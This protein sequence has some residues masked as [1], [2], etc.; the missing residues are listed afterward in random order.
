MV[1]IVVTG[2]RAATTITAEVLPEFELDR[3]S[4]DVPYLGAAPE[5]VESG[6]VV[7]VEQAIQ[8]IDGIK[9]IVSTASEGNAS[10]VVE[11]ALGADPKR[12]LDELTNNVQAITTFPSKPR[13]RSSASWSPAAR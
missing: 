9:Q 11:L 2:L 10:V 1:L 13:G 4:I 6:V 7:R 12:V 5:E 8:N 3:I